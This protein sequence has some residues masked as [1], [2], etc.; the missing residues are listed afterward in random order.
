MSRP[1]SRRATGGDAARKPAQTPPRADRRKATRQRW[2]GLPLRATLCCRAMRAV[3][4]TRHAT[5]RGRRRPR[6]P[7]SSP[8]PPPP[9]S[10]PPPLPLSVT[11]R[12]VVTTRG[13][14]AL[15]AASRAVSATLPASSPAL[16]TTT[17]RR[18]TR[19][20]LTAPRVSPRPTLQAT[21][22]TRP[23]TPSPTRR[24]CATGSRS[25]PCFRPR[26]RPKVSS[27]A[28]AAVASALTAAAAVA[29]RRHRRRPR[30]RP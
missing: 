29:W 1:P 9:A 30:C 5:L 15:R 24:P 7:A 17:R 18:S 25:M 2:R 20:R 16:G 10:H 11:R 22:P 28:A 3:R 27:S 4:A 23:R 14:A 12:L 26:N 19:R 8:P 21:S 6:L 13:A